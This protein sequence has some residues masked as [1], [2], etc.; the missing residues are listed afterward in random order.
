M[1]TSLLA[2][3]GCIVLAAIC[4]FVINGSRN[5]EIAARTMALADDPCLNDLD[6]QYYD[7]ERLGNQ[8]VAVAIFTQCDCPIANRYA[9]VIRQLYEQYHPQGVNLFLVF[10]DLHQPPEAIRAHLAEY[11]CPCPAF[12]D[13]DH[14][15]A[16]V[17][18][19]TV[20]PEAVVFDKGWRVTY[21]GRIDDQF[22]DVG[23]S[24]PGATTHDLANAISATLAGQP[25]AQS[26]TKAVGCY[27]ED[28]E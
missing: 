9:P 5:A 22:V 13:P 21:R 1:R 4:L 6:G 12:R 7:L 17:F 26:E 27:I 20:T 3:C 8:G 10:E 18:G 16:A 25:V 28:L 11:R 14:T 15:F 19:A 24:R 2:L 23:N